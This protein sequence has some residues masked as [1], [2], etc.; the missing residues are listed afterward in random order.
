MQFKAR[1]KRQI[2]YFQGE[3]DII[4]LLNREKIWRV[5]N[6]LVVN[7]IKFSPLDSKI[8]VLLGKWDDKVCIVIKDYGI[9]IPEK[10]KE[11]VFDLFTASKRVG[12]AGEKPFGLGLSASRQ[13]IEAHRGQIRHED[14]PEGGTIFYIELPD[15]EI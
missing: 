12:T 3:K 1:E 7:A 13:I 11:R 4:L 5:I 9:G 10:D 14:N 8:E 15:R 6:N 2:I